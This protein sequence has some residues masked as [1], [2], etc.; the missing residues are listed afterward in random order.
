MNLSITLGVRFQLIMY[1][2]M[3]M[4]IQKQDFI[5]KWQQDCQIDDDDD[6]DS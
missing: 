1:V 6:D 2:Y 3:Y 5:Q 4:N